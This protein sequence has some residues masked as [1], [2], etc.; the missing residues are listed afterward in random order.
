MVFLKD[1]RRIGIR[2]GPDLGPTC[3]QSNI[4]RRLWQVVTSLSCHD[5]DA[6][7]SFCYL[8][9]PIHIFLSNGSYFLP[10]FTQDI[11]SSSFHTVKTTP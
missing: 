7:P 1:D 10:F 2:I 6:D 3:L 4:N 5:M 11:L 9:V 8:F